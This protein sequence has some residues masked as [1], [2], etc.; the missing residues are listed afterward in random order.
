MP[1]LSPLGIALYWLGMLVIVSL[2][3]F[4]VIWPRT[5]QFP[6]LSRIGVSLL[7][8]ALIMEIWHNFFLW[9]RGLPEDVRKMRRRFAVW[10]G[11]RS[12]KGP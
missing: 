11:R 2:V 10:R 4:Y 3:G 6:V 7:L 12:K 5:A 1:R 9:V 8:S